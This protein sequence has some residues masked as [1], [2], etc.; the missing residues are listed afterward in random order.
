MF[1]VPLDFDPN[2]TFS[3]RDE[4]KPWLMLQLAPAKLAVAIERSDNVKI[5]FR[6]K[7]GQPLCPFRIRANFS[8]RSNLW[9][10]SVINDIHNHPVEGGI[11]VPVPKSHSPQIIQ[12][13]HA[14][15]KYVDRLIR[16]MGA[17]VALLVSVNI[18]QNCELSNEQKEASVARFVAGMVDEYLGERTVSSGQVM[19]LSPLLNDP[20]IGTQLPALAGL[21]RPGPLPPFNSLQNHLPP[22]PGLETAKT[23]NPVQLMK[24]ATHDLSEFKVDNM[25]LLLALAPGAPSPSERMDGL[26]HLHMYSGW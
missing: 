18:W 19:P 3:R 22:L 4:I 5:V 1:R 15:A 8:L 13:Q 9:T 25:G 2:T 11:L 12:R 16:K 23:L 14:S 10:I 24:T 20:D 6:C 7:S 17:D 21:S 26:G